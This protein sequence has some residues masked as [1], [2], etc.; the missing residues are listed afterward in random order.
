MQIENLQCVQ[1]ELAD[2]RK[3]ITDNNMALVMLMGLLDSW[4]N[5]ISAFLATQNDLF[6]VSPDTVQK[7]IIDESDHLIGN[8]GT[9]LLSSMQCAHSSAPL[10]SNPIGLTSRGRLKLNWYTCTNCGPGGH[11]EDRCW[12]LHPELRKGKG[13]DV[14]STATAAII[15]PLPVPPEIAGSSITTL[16]MLSNGTSTLFYFDVCNSWMIDS[17]ASDHISKYPTDFIP[18]S[19]HNTPGLIHL[20]NN[21]TILYLGIGEFRAVATVN[22]HSEHITLQCVLFAPEASGHFISISQLTDKGLQLMYK[23]TKCCILMPDDAVHTI[24]TKENGMYWLTITINSSS[25]LTSLSSIKPLYTTWHKCMA[26]ASP[27]LLQ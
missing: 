24:G 19:M 18:G 11:S 20:G 5:I 16:S 14:K 8:P 15:N 4:S 12:I 13:N 17:G 6:T 10:I 23:G 2:C 22:G 9:T 27:S 25:H 7:R 1:I 21:A 3:T 26:H